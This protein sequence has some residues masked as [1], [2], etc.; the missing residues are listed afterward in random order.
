M[1]PG[2][3]QVADGRPTRTV[4][5]ASLYFRI[6]DGIAAATTPADL[7]VLTSAIAAASP[8]PIELRALER[9]LN[10]RQSTLSTSRANG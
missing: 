7:E 10:A 1:R 6:V 9:K 5:D 4:M 8:H 2:F 3:A